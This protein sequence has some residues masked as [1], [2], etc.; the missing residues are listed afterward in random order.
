MSS[1]T[2]PS[3]TSLHQQS[4]AVRD[5]AFFLH[6]PLI[7]ILDDNLDRQ[8]LENKEAKVILQV[9]AHRGDGNWS[10]HY[11]SEE[12]GLPLLQEVL[13]YPGEEFIEQAFG[14]L[15]LTTIKGK[16]KA[17]AIDRPNQNTSTPTLYPGLLS[18]PLLGLTRCSGRQ[19]AKCLKGRGVFK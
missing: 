12:V 3:S 14:E 6:F 19:V 13:D 18:G 2:A 17:R 9:L 10:L 7:F 5:I 11:E 1:C 15:A 8:R 4:L 16:G